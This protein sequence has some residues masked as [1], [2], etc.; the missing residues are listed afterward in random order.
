[1]ELILGN[2]QFAIRSG[3]A[4][5]AIGE[6]S[7]LVITFLPYVQVSKLDALELDSGFADS[8]IERSNSMLVVEG[9]SAIL[10]R[11]P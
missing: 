5:S 9:F 7:P 2:E 11:A 10:C 1:M 8:R 4:Y 6:L 3:K